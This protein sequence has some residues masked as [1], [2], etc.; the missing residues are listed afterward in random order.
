MRPSTYNFRFSNNQIITFRFLFGLLIIRNLINC[1]LLSLLVLIVVFLIPNSSHAQQTP[2]FHSYSNHPEF[3]N[4]AAL[5]DGHV[6]LIYK[7]QW[8]EFEVSI[9]PRTFALSADLSNV[10][11]FSDKIAWGFNVLGDQAHIFKRTNIDFSFAYH[12]FNNDEKRLSLGAIAGLLNQRLDLGDIR[13]SSLNDIDV[14][15]GNSSQMTFDGGPGLFYTLKN[16]DNAFSA[17]LAL[18]QL[19][20]SDLN[21][22]DEFEQTFDNQLHILA[23]LRY[24]KKMEAIGLAG[25]ILF[26]GANGVDAT[27]TKNTVD[28]NLSIYFLDDLFWVNV[29]ARLNANTFLGGLGV[30]VGKHLSVQGTYEY[31]NELGSSYEVMLSYRFNK[32]NN[33][34]SSSQLVLNDLAYEKNNIKEVKKYLENT[35]FNE[36]TDNING[37]KNAFNEVHIGRQK[38]KEI[39]TKI[40]QAEWLLEQA[41]TNLDNYIH[42]SQAIF[43]SVWTAK[44][45]VEVAKPQNITSNSINKAYYSI[46]D[47]SKEVEEKVK[48]LR[49]EYSNL[50]SRIQEF[51]YRTG[52]NEPISQIIAQKDTE[53]MN[54][55][56]KSDLSKIPGIV[57]GS[58]VEYQQNE[59]INITYT[60]PYSEDTYQLG[61]AP[62]TRTLV[63]EHISDQ[64][65]RLQKQGLKIE[66]IKLKMLLQDELSEMQNTDATYP[67][68]GGFGLSN[69]PISVSLLDTETEETTQTTTEIK[70]L[71]KLSF[72]DLIALKLYGVE[73]YLKD[74]GLNG[75]RTSIPLNFEIFGPDYDVEDAQTMIIDIEIKP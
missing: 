16:D 57:R 5:G 30:N 63:V 74:Q 21:Y 68:L 58:N 11:S 67:Y 25:S 28:A 59:K 35:A 72:I 64:I 62:D 70:K 42:N 75:L 6:A 12:L 26:E 32:E 45:V 55:L 17:S 47:R 41:K 65:Q 38:P 33:N 36:I 14:F 18:P 23:G 49:K 8:T 44:R 54:F 66:S 50:I 39:E 60:F 37:A 10:I 53:K 46:L 69:I 20:T 13:V 34:N 48:H 29:G 56:L 31:H 22:S 15:S 2:Y 61:E 7:S 4:P 24:Y 27:F 1:L 73:Y 71:Q 51:R 3:Y 52:M 43:K 19:F 40:Y 9:A